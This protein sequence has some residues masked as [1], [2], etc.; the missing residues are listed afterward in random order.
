MPSQARRKSQ[1]V[2]I[3]ESERGEKLPLQK[4][5]K[6]TKVCSRNCCRRMPN[7]GAAKAWRVY[8]VSKSVMTR[9]SIR[10]EVLAAVVSSLTSARV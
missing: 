9:K 4:T 6:E 2:H 7:A 5:K 8:A 1:G 10:T 3:Q